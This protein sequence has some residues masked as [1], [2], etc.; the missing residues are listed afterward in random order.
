MHKNIFL[1]MTQE[2]SLCGSRGLT[3]EP[4]AQQSDRNNLSSMPGLWSF[5]G[6]ATLSLCLQPW[7][8]PPPW[9][10]LHPVMGAQDR[11][12][13]GSVRQVGTGHRMTPFLGSCAF[14]EL[15]FVLRGCLNSLEMS[16]RGE[17]WY[18]R[19]EPDVQ[20]PEELP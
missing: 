8:L 3:E 16:L 1:E 14:S 5:L 15:R 11:Q 4:D 10:V 9:H 18:V 17:G 12:K 7:H 2:L 19:P 20:E 13:G 6:L